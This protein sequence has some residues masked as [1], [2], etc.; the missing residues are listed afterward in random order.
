[1]YDI[2]KQK[3]RSMLA[4]AQ[5]ISL[6][7][8]ETITID[9]CSYIVVHAYLLQDWVRVPIILHLQKLESGISHEIFFF[10][11]FSILVHAI[12]NS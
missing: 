8:D 2:V 6:T 4:A 9:N 3:H 11:W 12:V 7:A 1:M 5:Y 10:L